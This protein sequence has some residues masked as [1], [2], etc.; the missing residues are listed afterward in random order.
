MVQ[1]RPAAQ[2]TAPA[3]AIHFPQLQFV[4]L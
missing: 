2:K 4:N 1:R 3:G